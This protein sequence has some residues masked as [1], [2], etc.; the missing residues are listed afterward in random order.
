MIP[1]QTFEVAQVA[2]NWHPLL[3]GIARDWR[4]SDSYSPYALAGT[5]S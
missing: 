2:R 4:G 3:A 1:L 5:S